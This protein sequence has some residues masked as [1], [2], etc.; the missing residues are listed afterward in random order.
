MPGMPGAAVVCACE[1][2]LDRFCKKSKPGTNWPKPKAD[3]SLMAVPLNQVCK[4]YSKSLSTLHKHPRF[5][6]RQH[7]GLA[8][9]EIL[10]SV[11]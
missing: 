11:L 2:V 3:V 7:Q 8:F 6:R 9:P 10:L 5:S 1:A 4:A